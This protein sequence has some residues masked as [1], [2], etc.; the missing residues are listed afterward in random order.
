MGQFFIQSPDRRYIEFVFDKRVRRTLNNSGREENPCERSDKPQPA[1]SDVAP[2]E[3]V[4]H[5]AIFRIGCYVVLWQRLHSP[6]IER[7][8]VRG[9]DIN[10]IYIHLRSIPHTLGT[11]N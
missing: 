3:V 7:S 1:V 4:L 2:P 11:V 9:G 6:K 5:C 8:G 10:L